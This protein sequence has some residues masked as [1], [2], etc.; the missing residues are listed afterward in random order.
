LAEV[1]GQRI[2]TQSSCNAADVT[3]CMMPDIRGTTS[4]GARSGQLNREL[5]EGAVTDTR[6]AQPI[7]D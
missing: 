1:T 4:D 3:R 5:L 7:A 2:S 6:R